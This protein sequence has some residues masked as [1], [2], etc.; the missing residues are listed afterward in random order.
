[1][2]E[3]AGQC[4]Q[5]GYCCTKGVC[6][7]GVWDEGRGCCAFLTGEGKC[8]AYERIQRY[9][10]AKMNPAF[11]AGCSST[12]FNQRRERKI[13]E[14]L[15]ARSRTEQVLALDERGVNATEKREMCDL[16]RRGQ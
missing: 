1:M 6:Q 9:P 8:V 13:A 7:F 16:W 10:A 5:C 3:F 12:L 4:V 2:D 11:G 15:A 14:I